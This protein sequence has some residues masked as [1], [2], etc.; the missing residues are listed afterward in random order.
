MARA[1]AKCPEC[2]EPVSQFAAGC[3]ICGADLEEAR[4]DLAEKQASRRVPR[5]E[6]PKAVGFG[7]SGDVLF[8]VLM[9]TLTIFAPPIGFLLGGFMAYR[10]NQEGRDNMRNIALGCAIAALL[11]VLFP[12]GIWLRLR[13][14]IGV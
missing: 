7:G 12:F 4:R 13:D 6:I 10:F 14:T 11:F 5:P 8:G 2:G 1:V 3:A 9:V